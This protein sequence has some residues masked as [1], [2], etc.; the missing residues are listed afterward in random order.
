MT[1][2]TAICIQL[3]EGSISSAS[4]NAHAKIA[5]LCHTEGILAVLTGADLLCERTEVKSRPHFGKDTG[6][7]IPTCRVDRSS[8][9]RQ[10]GIR[11]KEQTERT[12][13]KPIGF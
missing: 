10:M 2:K 1:E 8:A 3:T 12:K 5:L 4:A 6:G 7:R 11:N 9:W 13:R